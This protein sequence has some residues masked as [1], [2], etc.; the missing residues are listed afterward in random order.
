MRKKF[1]KKLLLLCVTA[2]CTTNMIVPMNSAFAYTEKEKEAILYYKY[3]QQQQN[4]NQTNYNSQLSLL[5]TKGMNEYSNGNYKNAINYLSRVSSQYSNKKDYNIA[6]GDSY[7]HLNNFNQAISYLT[8]AYQLGATDYTTLTG[9]GYSYMDTKNYSSAY[10]YLL[11]TTQLYASQPDPY[12]NLGLTCIQLNNTT[13]ELSS[14]QKLIQVA[15][16]YGTDPYIY[17][18]QIYTNNNDLNSALNYYV[19]GIQYFPNNS[20][21]RF[22]A[23]DIYFQASKFKQAAEYF[24]SAIYL[25]NNYVDAYYE[26]GFSYL[27]LNDVDDASSDCSALSELAPKSD[28]T[29]DLC[30]AVNQKIMEQQMQQQMMQDQ[31]QQQIDQQNIDDQ[32]MQ[33]V[34]QNSTQM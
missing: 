12:F 10:P 14:F 7:R 9:I 17:V 30:K 31:I 1:L 15:P 16:S 18:G 4:N 29:T 3:R 25:Q 8:R 26:R 34:M 19:K 23:G 33:E 28:S 32:N 22:L 5:Y 21:L 11:K 6:M 24:S 20:V 13:C 27:S 2:I